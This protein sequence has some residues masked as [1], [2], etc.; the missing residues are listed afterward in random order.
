MDRE[1][2]TESPTY[3]PK[4][5]SI[6][7]EIVD[8]SG[9]SLPPFDDPPRLHLS[10]VEYVDDSAERE[11][12]KRQ[13]SPRWYSLGMGRN[14]LCSPDPQETRRSAHRGHFTE[15]YLADVEHPA[16]FWLPD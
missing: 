7:E 4:R 11:S 14:V 1:P 10:Y 6:D 8:G 9:M 2:R 16:A 12:S 15:R 13:R 5:T 3:R